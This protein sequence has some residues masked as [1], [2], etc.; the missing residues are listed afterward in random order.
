M[1]IFVC[2]LILSVKFFCVH[3][4]DLMNAK[5]LKTV[6]NSSTKWHIEVDR[7]ICQSL[8][9]AFGQFSFGE[10]ANYAFSMIKKFINIKWRFCQFGE[11][12]LVDKQEI[13]SRC[14]MIAFHSLVETSGT[15][16]G[17]NFYIL[18]VPNTYGINFSFSE[19][20]SVHS[21]LCI[22]FLQFL[23][24]YHWLSTGV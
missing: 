24:L 21:G 10:L 17:N 5:K 2:F 14:R 4:E 19:F 20:K 7:E 23:F 6:V 9:F 1:H 18:K 3:M 8:K 22:L 15:L 16:L 11:I 12:F 13:L